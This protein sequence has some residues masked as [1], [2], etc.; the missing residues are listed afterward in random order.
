MNALCENL[1]A[2]IRQNNMEEGL[3]AL[4]A[5][6]SNIYDNPMTDLDI[7]FITDFEPDSSTSERYIR[8]VEDFHRLQNLPIDNEIAFQTKLIVS[9]KELQ[10]LLKES[11]FMDKDTYRVNPV[12]EKSEF[13]NSKEMRTRLFINVLTTEHVLICG[14]ERC[15]QPLKNQAWQVIL[16]LVTKGYGVELNDIEKILDV[17][18]TDPNTGASGEEYLGYKKIQQSKVT[19]LEKQLNEQIARYQSSVEIINEESAD[20]AKNIFNSIIDSGMKFKLQENIL[21]DPISLSINDFDMS[22]PSNGES[23]EALVEHFKTKV[24]PYSSNFSSKKFMGFPDAGNSIAGTAGSLF[25]DFMQQNMI[26]SSFCAPVATFMEI[27]V[28]NWL[29]QAVGYDTQQAIRGVTDI[30]GIL[31]YGGTGSNTTAMLLARERHVKNTMERGVNNPGNFKVLIPKG[32]GHYSI[33]SSL[34]WIG[35]G[36]NVIEV[37]TQDFKYDLVALEKALIENS[38]QIMAVVAYAGDS[39]T[40]TIG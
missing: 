36:D 27:Q 21:E 29:R 8:A 38:G 3:F 22:I 24:L 40:Q 25:A 33:A 10:K 26:N 19:M 1:Q 31:T 30:G 37:H 28:V 16:D 14:D 5:Y 6:G 34:K 23:M 4:I 9:K 32:I 39:R 13:L 18:Y 35:V 7:L 12:I 11:P 2:Y 15:F 20:Y 17:L